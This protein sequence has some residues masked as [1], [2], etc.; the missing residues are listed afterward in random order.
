LKGD[1]STSPLFVHANP[2]PDGSGAINIAYGDEETSFSALDP[3]TTYYFAIY[4]YTNDGNAIDYKNDGTAPTSSATTSN[5]QIV[6][7]EVENFDDG[8]GNWTT[9][10]LQGDNEWDRDNTYGIGNTPCASA[11]GYI[12]GS[13]PPEYEDSDDWLISPAMNFDEYDNEKIE[14]QNAMNYTGP[15]L[16]LKVSTDYDGGGNPLTATWTEV[17]YSQSG[18]GFAWTFSEQVDLSSFN[19]TDVYVAFHF[20]STT[21]SSATWE[22]DDIVITGEQE[23]TIEPEPTAYPTDFDADAAATN[24]VISWT[25][26]TGAQLPTAYIIYAGDDDNLPVPTDGQPVPD[27]TDLSDGSGALNVEYGEEEAVFANLAP[28]TTYYFSIYSYTNTGVNTDYKNDGT[29]PTSSATTGYSPYIL[30]QGF[31]N[32]FGNWEL[33]SVTGPQGWQIDEGYG[34][35]D[36]PCARMSG[37]AGAAVENEDW[38]ISPAMN[39]DNYENEVLTFNNAQNFDNPPMECKISTDYNGGGNP[40]SANWTDISYNMSTGFY[41][42]VES[43]EIDLSGYNGTAVYVAFVYYSTT[44]ESAV[45]EVDEILVEDG[46]TSPEPTNYPT[47]FMAEGVGTGIYLEWEDA[48]GVQ[49]PEGYIVYAGI[50]ASLPVPSDGTPVP[51]DTDL[52]DGSGAINVSYGDEETNFTAL[53]PSTTYYFS[54]YPYTNNGDEID[55]KNDGVAPTANATTENIILVT[56]EEEN[57]NADWGNWTRI[58]MLGNLEWDRDNTYGP[59][60][61]PCAAMTGYAGGSPPEYEENDDW[62][63]SPSMNFDNFDNE[64]IVF[65]NAMNYTGPDLELKISTDYDGGGDPTSAQWTSLPYSMSGGGFA[66]TNSGEV[67][68]SPF[69]GS[70]VHIAFH[71][72]NPSTGSATWE[73]DNIVI[74]GEEEYVIKPEPTNY[75]TN[76]VAEA[77]GTTAFLEWTDAIGAQLPDSYIILVSTNSEIPVPE[78]GVPI[79]DDTNLGN[80]SGAMNVGFGVGDASFTGMASFTTYY[81]AIYPYTNIGANIN[82]KND[83]TAPDANVTTSTVI[84]NTLT[85]VDFNEGWGGWTPISMV[86]PQVWER[87]NTYGPDNTPCAAMTGYAGGSPPEYDAN[88]DWLVSPAFNFNN[89]VN[90][91][92]TF[93]NAKNYSG[94]DVELRVSTNYTGNGDPTTANWTNVNYIKSGGDFDWVSSGSVDLSDFTGNPNAYVALYFSNTSSGSATWEIDDILIMAEQEYVVQEEPSNYPV[95]FSGSGLGLFAELEWTE[96]TGDQLPD[97]YVIFAGLD[98]NLPIP[99]DGIPLQDDSDLSDGTGVVN[100]AYGAGAYVFSTGLDNY[101]T[102]YFTIYPYTNL[103]TDRNYKNDGTAPTTI[104]QTTDMTVVTI[105]EESFN[106]GWGD[107]TPVNVVGAQEWNRQNQYGPDDTP[108]AAMSGYAGGSPPEYDENDDWLISPQLN[109]DLY[110]LEAIS[111]VNAKNYNGD[112][113]QLKYSTDYT[114]NDDPHSATWTNLNFNKSPGDFEWVSSGWVDLSEIIGS[115]AYVAFQFTNSEGTSATWELDDVLILGLEVL[116][117]NDKLAGS[118]LVGMYPNPASSELSIVQNKLMFDMMEIRTISGLSV[119]QYQIGATTESIDVSALQAGIYIVIFTNEDDGLIHTEKLIIR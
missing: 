63:I 89:Y 107:W 31:D 54:I 25:D 117:V 79:P 57:F 51:N 70:S 12:S 42:W 50:N 112:D 104:A 59:D 18:G 4:P 3:S 36:P 37:F 52:S 11:T 106:S 33:A 81:F 101:T 47:E 23:A 20:T 46:S 19:G 88:E 60:F 55:Y 61:T 110:E 48:T 115:S 92:M 86:G 1:R 72:V 99:E 97:G 77:T 74:T 35:P 111:F 94:P 100:V 38:L 83:G 93:M 116:S 69:N 43:G 105:Q 78:D 44:S 16:Q 90:I 26:A 21:V 67:D 32:G 5:V 85:F 96:S 24:I 56:I 68:L 14:F 113:V 84:I 8:W 80:G 15:D 103:G 66:W 82:Y 73:V 27:D 91:T 29:A 28:A 98:E 6:D 62:L 10:S 7:I 13:T 17:S 40:G 76:F 45:W 53:D 49:I 58:S 87:D 22:V 65:V 34:F 41:E 75:P 9:I 114:G 30:Y 108:C 102:Y 71:F 109:F 2:P 95:Q 118:D 39:L 119:N 64:K